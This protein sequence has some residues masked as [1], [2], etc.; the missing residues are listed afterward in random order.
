MSTMKNHLD[1]KYKWLL[2]LQNTIGWIV[3]LF[4]I[5]LMIF[6]SAMGATA[7]SGVFAIVAILG[8]IF[9][10]IGLVIVFL[11]S[12]WISSWWYKN[13]TYELTDTVFKKEY[14]IL[15]KRNTGIPYERIQNVDIVAPLLYRIF[16]LAQLNIQTAGGSSY[17]V[18]VGGAEGRLPGVSRQV[19]TELQEELLRRARLH[20]PQRHHAVASKVDGL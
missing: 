3:T 8:L 4:F 9:P 13:Y 20:N 10:L 17:S 5:G 2:V 16:G 6:L 19:A 14:G 15:T 7:D 1:P 12:I 18:A 11:I